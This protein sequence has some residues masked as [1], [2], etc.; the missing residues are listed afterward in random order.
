MTKD[1]IGGSADIAKLPRFGASFMNCRARTTNVSR[2]PIGAHLHRQRPVI[3]I[4]FF[5]FVTKRLNASPRI[6]SSSSG[7]V[8]GMK[9]IGKFL[10]MSVAFC[11]IGLFI[12]GLAL[13]IAVGDCGAT[14]T[15]AD[16]AV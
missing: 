14:L 1:G 11:G 3:A 5:I 6:G 8:G 12:A 9:K 7:K 13:T 4:S 10:I 15:V 16:H 2:R